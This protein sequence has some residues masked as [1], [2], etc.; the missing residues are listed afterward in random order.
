MSFKRGAAATAG[1]P[2]VVLSSKW[3]YTV[4]ESLLLLTASQVRANKKKSPLAGSLL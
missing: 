3:F 2:P 1:K 4:S